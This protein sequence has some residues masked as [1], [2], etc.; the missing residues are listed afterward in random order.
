M[1]RVRPLP[2]GRR[3]GEREKEGGGEE[4]GIH[5]EAPMRPA[6]VVLLPGR[7]A[8]ASCRRPTAPP[9]TPAPLLLLRAPGHTPSRAGRPV[10]AWR[11]AVGRPLR[12]SACWELPAGRRPRPPGPARRGAAAQRANLVDR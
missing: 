4:G 5:M 8:A 6:A 3:G 9:H 7:P 12:G 2:W 1:L 10:H 11:A